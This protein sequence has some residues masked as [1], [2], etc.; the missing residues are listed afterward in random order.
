MS[1]ENVGHVTRAIPGITNV[2]ILTVLLLLYSQKIHAIDG[3]VQL[4]YY[5]IYI[6]D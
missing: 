6:Y 3:P 4:L 5:I 2:F 1:K